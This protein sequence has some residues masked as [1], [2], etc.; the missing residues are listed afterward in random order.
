[1]GFEGE[2]SD[3]D[4][5]AVLQRLDALE[6]SNRKKDE[7]IA[8]LREMALRQAGSGA[9]NQGKS[10]EQIANEAADAAFRAEIAKGRPREQALLARER[11]F[12]EAYHRE[13]ALAAAADRDRMIKEYVQNQGAGG[14]S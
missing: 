14:A 3:T 2:Y 4:A 8:R 5:A 12:G 6:E 13:A 10:P 9:D 7:E 1:M 11:A